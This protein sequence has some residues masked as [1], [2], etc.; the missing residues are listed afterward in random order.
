MQRSSKLGQCFGLSLAIL[1]ACLIVALIAKYSVD[2]PYWD[3]W[4]LTLIFE[5]LSRGTLSL[6][7]LFAQQNEYRQFFPNLIFVALGWLTRWDVR[8]EMFVSF[9]LAC[10]VSFNIYRLSKITVGGSQG[11][12]FLLLFISNLLIF[13]PIQYENWL[14]GEQ[15]VY[16]MPIACVTTCIL[17]AY[18]DLSLRVK[19]LICVCL[20]TVST[21]SSANGMLCWIIIPPVLAWARTRGESRGKTCWV[22]GWIICVA[23]NATLYFHGYVKP[24]GNP[25]LLE[26]LLHPLNALIYFL[27]FL[28]SLFAIGGHPF[29]I[30]VIVGGALTAV[31]GLL[32]LYIRRF[33]ADFALVSRSIGWLMIALYSVLTGVIVT[34]G[35][36]GFGVEQSTS[37]RYTTFSLYLAV[38]LVNLVPIILDDATRRGYFRSVQA[39]TSQLIPLMAAL[40][41]LVQAL[42]LFVVIRHGTSVILRQRL[43]AKACLLF[44]NVAQEECV[45]GLLPDIDVLKQDANALN[46]LGYLRPALIESKRV[47]DIEASGGAVDDYGSFNVLMRVDDGAYAASGWAVLPS[48]GRPADAI[49]LAY[50]NGGGDDIVF[51]LADVSGERNT[52]ARGRDAPVGARWQKTFSTGTLPTLPTKLR[53]WAFDAVTGKAYQL[54]GTHVVQ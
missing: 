27:A 19:F 23:L 48:S 11:Q 46:R 16:Y 50:D 44:I 39:Y 30:A 12:R 33:S 24:P 14:S 26:P 32:C 10:L 21:F 5:K 18:S 22:F 38:A 35:R 4:N 7:D 8:Y 54:N 13:S 43:H 31:S 3:Q 47:Q 45:K 37:Y 52:E 28:G 51:A 2:V 29:I 15:V 17:I 6:A 42:V 20:S 36:L 49:L 41:T 25:S 53:A 1:P 34:F 40:L 9:L